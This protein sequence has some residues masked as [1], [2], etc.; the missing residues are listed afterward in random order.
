MRKLP[1]GDR[2]CVEHFDRQTEMV[3]YDKIK[4]VPHGQGVVAYGVMYSWFTDV[5]SLVSAEQARRLMHPDPPKKEEELAEH[6]EM[7]QDTMRR[8][9][10]QGEELKLAPVFKINALRLLMTGKAKE[11]FDLREGDRDTTD[12]AKSYEEFPG[13]VKDY[14]RR[15]SLDSST[16]EKMQHGGD[17]MDVGAVGGWSWSEDTS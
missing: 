12:V 13:K 5:S 4:M 8:L 14:S 7:W 9:E 16:K 3:A 11:Y 6:E 1:T 17:P 2:R 10:A 15:G